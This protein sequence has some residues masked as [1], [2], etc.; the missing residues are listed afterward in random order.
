MVSGRVARAAVTCLLAGVMVACN[1]GQGENQNRQSATGPRRQVAATLPCQAAA[2]GPTDLTEEFLVAD[3][4]PT[5]AVKVIANAPRE[6][7]APDAYEPRDGAFAALK[8]PI[9]VA[10]GATVT[11]AIPRS[12]Q[13]GVAL[14]FGDDSDPIEVLPSGTRLFRLDQGETSVEFQGCPDRVSP[15][16]GY[17][18][19]DGP[20]CVELSVQLGDDADRIRIPFGPATCQSTERDFAQ[21]PSSDRG[22]A[23][24]PT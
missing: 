9:V 15:F 18:L 17:F 12:E 14:L 1:S 10:A 13:A 24:P 11:V 20:R 22:S 7:S 8:S 2:F 19:V 21:P 3:A 23:P 6:P 16:T 4:G 5:Q